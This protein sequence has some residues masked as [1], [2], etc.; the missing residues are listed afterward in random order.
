MIRSPY[1]LAWLIFAAAFAVR[2]V[3]CLVSYAVAGPEGLMSSDSVGFIKLAEMHLAALSGAPDQAAWAWLGGDNS[4][5]PLF[6]WMLSASLW[7]GGG[8]PLAF[9]LLQ[10]L[11]DAGTCLV[12]FAIGGAIHRRLAIPAAVIAIANPTMIVVSGLV[13]S[14]TLFIFWSTLSILA[15]LKLWRGP[16]WGRKSPGA[17][18][19]WGLILGVA[20][21]AAMLTRVT[22]LPWFAATLFALAVTMLIRRQWTGLPPLLASIIL[23]A[24]IFSPV[25]L[26]NLDQHN[27]WSTTAQTGAYTL[28]WLVPLTREVADGTPW[29]KGSAEMRAKFKAAHPNLPE[30]ADF[31]RS[32]LMTQMAMAEFATLGPAAILRAWMRGAAINLGSPAATVAPLVARL[33]KGSFYGTSG[34]GG[35][36]A[37][38]KRFLFD[39]PSPTYAWIITIGLLGIAIVRL[40]QLVGLVGMLAAWRRRRWMVLYL[41][42]WVAFILVISGPVAS[43]K[44]R[45]PI[46]PAMVIFL[47]AGWLML[48]KRRRFRRRRTPSHSAPAHAPGVREA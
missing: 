33:Q 4:L 6:I 41:A 25:T 44:Y 39:N 9:V 36:I 38:L 11:L 10:S 46:E 35:F 3:Y 19:K 26:R 32:R 17:A 28:Y 31:L 7:I 15:A 30:K 22:I 14:D 40:I 21:G 45:A 13:L 8:D 5:L 23:A 29:E 47:A 18:W 24:L 43:P 42:A 27:T 12:M 2:A 20:V 1:R 34:E 16:G 48:V 37:K